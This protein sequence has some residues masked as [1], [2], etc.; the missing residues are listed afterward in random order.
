A[1]GGRSRV[2]SQACQATLGLSRR[3]RSG[4]PGSPPPSAPP[5]RR[6]SQSAEPISP[7]APV[8]RT[9]TVL[10]DLDG[11]EGAGLLVQSRD[12][13]ALCLLDHGGRHLGGDLAV[14]DAGDDV[15]LGQVLVGDHLGDA[16]G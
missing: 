6:V 5:T 12:S 8:T 1:A 9:F 14:E 11:G 4:S 10:T 13:V 15:V 3:A 16:F 7:L 2:G